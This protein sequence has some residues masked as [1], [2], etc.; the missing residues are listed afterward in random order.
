M[1]GASHLRS[2]ASLTSKW[3]RTVWMNTVPQSSLT[4]GPAPFVSGRE[5]SRVH[6]LFHLDSLLLVHSIMLTRMWI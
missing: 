1:D 2:Y 6:Y 3:L 5:E 4:S